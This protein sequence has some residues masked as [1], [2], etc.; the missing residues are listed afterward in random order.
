MK[1]LKKI[2]KVRNIVSTI[3]GTSALD[4]ALKI[5]GVKEQDEVL[6]PTISFVAPANAILYN[7]AIPHFID[8]DLNH[9]GVDP[10]KV[11]NL[12]AQEYKNKKQNMYK[13]KYK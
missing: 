13:F 11:K 1:K 9:F 4:I 10:E 6:L 8:S 7:N 12:F 5:V 3:N 2:I